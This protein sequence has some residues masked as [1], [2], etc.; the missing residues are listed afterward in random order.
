MVIAPFMDPQSEIR[1]VLQLMWGITEEWRDKMMDGYSL[2][3]VPGYL[4]D[5]DEFVEEFYTQWADP[6]KGEKVRQH[7]LT[8]QI[9]QRTSV[10]VYND[11]FN[12][13]L[14]LT[15]MDSTN[16]AVV[17][18][19]K[20]GLKPDIQSGAVIM[21]MVHPHVTF[22]ECQQLMIAIDKRLQ[23]TRPCQNTQPCF[24]APPPVLHF[25][26]P[27]P[28]PTARATTAAPST[29]RATMS[30]SPALQGQTPAGA[31]V[32]WQ[33]TKLMPQERE[34]LRQAG[35]CFYCCEQGHMANQCPRCPQRVNAV[36]TTTDEES[37]PHSDNTTHINYAAPVMPPPTSDFQ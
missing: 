31:G 37:P 7:I 29:P 3:Q 23:K 9:T 19:Y 16:P 35:Q 12:Q 20:N 5:W 17:H 24:I 14:A 11:L 26:A 4:L 6:H 21:L 1:W 32:A 18:S 25:H 22:H 30:A 34:G 36:A 8:Q 27:P 10:K 2:P 15:G 33:Y 13:A 28:T